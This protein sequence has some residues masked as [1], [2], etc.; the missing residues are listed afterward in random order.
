V[1][2][3]AVL[4]EDELARAGATRI[5]ALR[6]AVGE[7]CGVAPEALRAAF[8]ICAHGTAASGAELRIEHWAGRGLV[9][10]DMEVI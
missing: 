2:L 1:P 10:R 3:A 5:T 6:V 8:P 4:A 7:L 9:L